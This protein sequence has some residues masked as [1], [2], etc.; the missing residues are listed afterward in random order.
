MLAA[1][2]TQEFS[3]ADMA[4]ALGRHRSSISREFKRNCCWYDGFYRPSKAQERTNGRRSR[5]RRN[6]RISDYA[7]RLVEKYLRLKWAPEQIAG[8]LQRRLAIRVSH[9]TIYLYIWR[10]RSRGGTLWMHLRGAQKKRRKR[11]ATHDSRGR[12]AGKRHI[13]ERPDAANDRSEKGHWE[14]DTVVGPVPGSKDCILSLVE[15]RTGLT[16]I[17]KLPDRTSDALAAR[18]LELIRDSRL[19]F[20]TI[21]ADNGSEF[22]EYK[23]IEDQ[24]QARFFFATPHHSWERGTV[25]NTNGLIRQYIPKR[26]DMGALTQ[27]HCNSIAHQLNTRPRKRLDFKTPLEAYLESS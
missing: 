6:R 26:M 18:A 5:S 10:D 21:T 15:R 12:L 27:R 16:L 1:L 23:R 8:W 22:H 24:T 17:G 3:Q 2:R 11:Y 19:A 9:E 13:S 20:K 25:E 7:W 14:I 4:R